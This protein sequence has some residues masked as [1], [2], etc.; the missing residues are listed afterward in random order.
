MLC[1]VVEAAVTA[2]QLTKVE[3]PP[4][5]CHGSKRQA[6]LEPEYE[7]GRRGR[8]LTTSV[9]YTLKYSIDEHLGLPCDVHGSR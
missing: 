2:S 9:W 4:T 1:V 8:V 5:S 6:C 7:F 3:N